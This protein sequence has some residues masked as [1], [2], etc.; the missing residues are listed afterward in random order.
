MYADG[1]GTKTNPAFAVRWW[2]KAAQK[3][4]AKA[5]YNVGSSYAEGRGVRANKRVAAIWFRK[6]VS[7]GH[8][9][10]ARELS[11]LESIRTYR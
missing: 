1:V 6:A 3:G 10:A 4:D 8:K 11:A 7:H 2:R 9:K 5:E